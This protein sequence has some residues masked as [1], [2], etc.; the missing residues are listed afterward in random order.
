MQRLNS[1]P[2]SFGFAGEIA[3]VSKEVEITSSLTKGKRAGDQGECVCLCL[4]AMH[5]CYKKKKL[6]RSQ[7]AESKEL[8]KRIV[9]GEGQ[10]QSVSSAQSGESILI[11]DT[12]V[13]LCRTE[14]RDLK[15]SSCRA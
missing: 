6:A 8:D 11:C 15:G 1:R 3:F 14:R 2:A 10:Y 5:V 9:K 4:I 13:R 12:A 7:K